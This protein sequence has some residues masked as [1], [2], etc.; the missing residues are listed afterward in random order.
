MMIYIRD[1]DAA[2]FLTAGVHSV[3]SP[4]L[5]RVS[6]ELSSLLV[7]VFTDHP[8]SLDSFPNTLLQ[9]CKDCKSKISKDDI[10]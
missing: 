10:L 9:Y 8:R 3:F 2:A 5:A 6:L 4:T 1:E 7:I